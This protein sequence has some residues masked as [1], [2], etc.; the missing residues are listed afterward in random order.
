[1]KPNSNKSV[2]VLLK[3]EKEK[4]LDYAESWFLN[5]NPSNK[6]LLYKY[7]YRT[8]IGILFLCKNRAK[9][10]KKEEKSD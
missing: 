4:I 9:M 5:L 7:N 6:I 10:G 1:M 8:E 2:Y 3:H